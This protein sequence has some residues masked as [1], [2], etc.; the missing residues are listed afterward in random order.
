MVSL[1]KDGR[2]T[3]MALTSGGLST[4]KSQLMRDLFSGLFTNSQTAVWTTYQLAFNKKP[5]KIHHLHLSA[6]VFDALYFSMLGASFFLP[7]SSYF[8]RIS[9]HWLFQSAS[10]NVIGFGS[11]WRTAPPEE[12]ITTRLTLLDLFR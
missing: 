7:S 6:S 9:R 5:K 2:T 12:V 11:S 10:V 1:C 3:P 8:L 4:T